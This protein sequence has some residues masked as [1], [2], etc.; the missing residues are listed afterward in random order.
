LHIS[1]TVELYE[2]KTQ[3]NSTVWSSL[4]SPPLPIC[5]RQSYIIPTHVTALKETITE[6]GITSKHVLSESSLK[7][8]RKRDYE[9]FNILQS[10]WPV[11]VSL[12]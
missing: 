9:N 7:V 5:E 4:N 12:K 10:L 8:S 11:A 1:A 6:K 3:A 2:G